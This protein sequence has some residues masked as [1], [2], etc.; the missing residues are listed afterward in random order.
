MTEQEAFRKRLSAMELQAMQ[1]VRRVERALSTMGIDVILD[2]KPETLV[3]LLNLRGAILKHRLPLS[4]ILRILLS[5]YRRG[6]GASSDRLGVSIKVL[7]GTSAMKYLDSQVHKKFPNGE[8]IKSWR[9]RKQQAINSATFR[10]QLPDSPE[11]FLERYLEAL[12]EQRERA[13]HEADRRLLRR[14]RNS[15]WI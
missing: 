5:K 13:S 8:Q 15:P 7:T 9:S 10:V 6:R 14:Y 4:E 2:S 1:F 3:R 11:E 12:T